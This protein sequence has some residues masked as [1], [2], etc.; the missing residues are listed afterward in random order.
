[1]GVE[2]QGTPVKG[3]RADP[4]CVRAGILLTSGVLRATKEPQADRM[5]KNESPPTAGGA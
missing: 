5:R 4:A 3:I 1:M 2:K